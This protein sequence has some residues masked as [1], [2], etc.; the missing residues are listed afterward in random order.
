MQRYAR[1]FLR[2]FLTYFLWVFVVVQAF[3][4]LALTVA[5]VTSR[6]YIP[7][8]AFAVGFPDAVLTLLPVSLPF[9]VL[10]AGLLFVREVRSHGGFLSIQLA[11][12]DPR[13]LHWPLLVFGVVLSLGMAMLH[14]SVLPMALWHTTHVVK[15]TAST[16]EALATRLA[17]KPRFLSG[18]TAS[19]GAVEEGRM[20]DFV[21]T[22][23]AQDE[24]PLAVTAR[25][26]EIGL[27]DDGAVLEVRLTEGRYLRLGE[28]NE[29]KTNLRFGKLV[30]SLDAERLSLPSK[31]GLI[32]LKY[33]TDHELS[34]LPGQLV[35]L[36][37]GG[38]IPSE[39]R[40]ARVAAVQS[41]RLLRF[42]SAALP[43]FVLLLVVMYLGVHAEGVRRY[44]L[45][46][47]FCMLLLLQQIL[48]DA[49]VDKK[50][51]LDPTWL[52]LLP[53]AQAVL[54]LLAAPWLLRERKA[55]H[56]A[57]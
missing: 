16:T 48:I 38:Q 10:V 32:P 26:A 19:F 13:P 14:Q 54:G 51:P 30:L 12:R 20:R 8:S 43:L 11:G 22:S 1:S 56:A 33:Y 39:R 53:S 52:V 3:F 35:R 40:R 44:W 24:E 42:Q 50:G 41:V 55:A 17:R 5:V 21:M 6:P 2:T 46:G 15:T 49:R 28:Q 18:Y 27:V 57:G 45:V 25:E 34:L 23:N 37:R 47:T 31:R 4:G 7:L 9:T 36:L 29:V